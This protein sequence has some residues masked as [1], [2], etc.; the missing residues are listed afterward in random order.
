MP[1]ITNEL[2]Y[3]ILKSIQTGQAEIKATLA[4]HTHQLIRVREKINALRSDD[5]RRES[6]QAQMDTRLQRIEN[7]LNLTDA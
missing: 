5:L 1:Q 6:L 3:E 2:L 7:R 4:D